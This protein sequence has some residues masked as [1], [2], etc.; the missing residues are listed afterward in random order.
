[1]PAIGTPATPRHRRVRTATP[2]SDTALAAT[3]TVGSGTSDIRTTVTATRVGPMDGTPT[4][5]TEM[6]ATEMSGADGTLTGTT[7]T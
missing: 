2:T 7:D 3:M 4:S 6:S 5:A 1:M